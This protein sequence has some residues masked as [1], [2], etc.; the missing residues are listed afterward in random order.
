[1]QRKRDYWVCDRGI[2]H[3]YGESCDCMQ[4]EPPRCTGTAPKVNLHDYDT[5]P[6]GQMQEQE[7]RIARAWE[8]YD[9]D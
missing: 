3:D 7:R 8:R 1:M 2:T 9:R 6:R 5:T 4:E